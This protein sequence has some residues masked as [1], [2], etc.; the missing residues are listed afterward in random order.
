VHR[1]MDWFVSILPSRIV[2]ESSLAS[3]YDGLYAN[4]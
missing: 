4:A 2:M 1:G 3:G